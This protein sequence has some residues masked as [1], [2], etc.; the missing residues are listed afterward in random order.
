MKFTR[1][2]RPVGQGAFF[3]ECFDMGRYE[4]IVVYDCGSTSKEPLISEIKQFKNEHKSFLDYAPVPFNILFISHF[5]DDHVSGLKE[6]LKKTL[7]DEAFIDELVK[8]YSWLGID[9]SIVETLVKMYLIKKNSDKKS[10][11]EELSFESLIESFSVDRFFLKNF[12]YEYFKFDKAN[13]INYI[14][15]IGENLDD[16]N[17]YNNYLENFVDNYISFENDF[18]PH[19]AVIIPF[20]YPNLIKILLPEMENELS[21]ET[22]GALQ[23]LFDSDI[24]IIGLDDSGFYNNPFRGDYPFIRKEEL[25]EN[26]LKTID[27]YTRIRISDSDKEDCWYYMPFNTIPNNER[28]EK[29]LFE[30]FISL[31]HSKGLLNRWFIDHG[32]DKMDDSEIHEII[33]KPKRHGVN[34]SKSKEETIIL[35]LENFLKDGVSSLLADPA[36]IDLFKSHLRELYK[37]ASPGI[38]NVTAINV[39]SLNVLSW[40]SEQLRKRQISVHDV[41]YKKQKFDLLKW[42]LYLFRNNKNAYKSY[43]EYIADL[44]T[45]YHYNEMMKSVL[46]SCLYTG[47]C[48]MEDHFFKYIDD[49]NNQ[50]LK[51]SIG[52]LQIP[53]H[54][55]KHNYDKRILLKPVFSSFINFKKTLRLS[56]NAQKIESDF[57]EVFRP[58]FEITENEETRFVQSVEWNAPNPDKVKTEIKYS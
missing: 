5:D 20:L 38:K 55:R 14:I 30:L 52:L 53:H 50:I 4:T 28:K 34:R 6:L 8:E 2:L 44:N 39:N 26:G 3:T 33:N 9:K 49:I 18:C 23:A 29:F 12:M 10:F 13:H 45:V 25:Y 16:E 51:S 42:L 27:S 43:Q 40:G 58:C 35:E 36:T 37:K 22:F 19:V 17:Y 47:D 11:I 41:V 1:T 21:M 57:V 54:G 46:F 15:H 24:K 48:L 7:V 32:G 56:A 31:K